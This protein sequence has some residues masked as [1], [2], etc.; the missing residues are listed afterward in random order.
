MLLLLES[1]TIRPSLIFRK[2]GAHLINKKNVWKKIQIITIVLNMQKD[3]WTII[4]FHQVLNNET[5]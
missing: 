5:L 3:S 4:N 1:S 2:N